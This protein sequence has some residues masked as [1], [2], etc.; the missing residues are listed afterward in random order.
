[1]LAKCLMDLDGD[2]RDENVRKSINAVRQVCRPTDQKRPIR[3]NRYGKACSEFLESLRDP[4]VASNSGYG[5]Y[6]ARERTQANKC[7]KKFWPKCS[8]AKFQ[9]AKILRYR[10]ADLKPWLNK[11]D[12]LALIH[13]VRDPRGIIASKIK[14]RS[15]KH[16]VYFTPDGLLTKENFKAITSHAQILCHK[17]NADLDAKRRYKKSFSKQIITIKYEDLAMSP[18]DTARKIYKFINMDMTPSVEAWIKKNTQAKRDAFNRARI[19]QRANS[20]YEAVSWKQELTQEAITSITQI[21]KNVLERM[22]YSM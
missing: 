21:C 17:M 15:E 4:N 19:T 20:T 14:D 12:N 5:K 18:M 22:G 7:A 13:Y 2:V 3:L 8:A 10:L 1:M 16:K 9:A 11:D 6:Q